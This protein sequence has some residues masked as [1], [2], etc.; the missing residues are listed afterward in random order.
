MIAR[1]RARPA[2]RALT[3][4]DP[5]TVAIPSSSETHRLAL[6]PPRADPADAEPPTRSV[7]ALPIVTAMVPAGPV[8][9]IGPDGAVGPPL[10]GAAVDGITSSLDDAN[11]DQ[12]P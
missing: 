12:L 1:S 8:E 6:A 3:V 11:G 10:D 4:P 9:L 5:S 7:I 2:A